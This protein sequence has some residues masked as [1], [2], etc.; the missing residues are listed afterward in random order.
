MSKRKHEKD[1]FTF[2]DQ[3]ILQRSAFYLSPFANMIMKY[4]IYNHISSPPPPFSKFSDPLLALFLKR[5]HPIK[6]QVSKRFYKKLFINW[7]M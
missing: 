3:L 1:L 2:R 7:F 4:T 6:Y 5:N